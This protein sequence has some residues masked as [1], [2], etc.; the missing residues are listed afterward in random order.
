M[1]ELYDRYGTFTY[2]ALSNLIVDRVHASPE[3]LTQNMH[4]ALLQADRQGIIY[5]SMNC[6]A[7]ELMPDL[8]RDMLRRFLRERAVIHPLRRILNQAAGQAHVQNFPE[9]LSGAMT[10]LG[11][12]EALRT[13]PVAEPLPARGSELPPPITY[14]RTGLTFI[15]DFTNG[16]RR[17]DANGLL[18]VFSGGKTTLGLQLAVESA[19]RA[20]AEGNQELSVFLSYEEPESKVRP[21]FWANACNIRR[22]KVERVLAER[23]WGVLTTPTN[24]EQYEY[25]LAGASAQLGGTVLSETERWDEARPWLNHCFAFLDMSGS[26]DNPGA[27]SGY[28]DEIVGSLERLLHDRN[29]TLRTV[30]LDYAGIMCLRYMDA[31]NIEE[32]KLRSYLGRLGDRI[33]RRVSEHFNCTAWLLHQFNADQATKSP[34]ALLHHTH[35]AEARNFAENLAVCG[36]LGPI[37]K[38]TGCLTLNWSKV[39]YSSVGSRPAPILQ[40]DGDFCRMADVSTLYTPD[41]TSGQFL[42]SSIARTIQGGIDGDEQQRKTP[43]GGYQLPQLPI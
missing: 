11:R 18:G 21:L 36:C 7:A 25:E 3:V 6:P 33:R 41:P 2:E 15:D 37:H 12:I 39:R 4:T 19:R 24:L 32:E 8:G 38:P 40:I 17:G 20:N 23:N 10:E 26:G 13:T 28:V 29:T 34:T 31:H 42:D 27:G 30:V 9:L 35:S 43:R 14:V 16:Q 22:A 1:C 5:S